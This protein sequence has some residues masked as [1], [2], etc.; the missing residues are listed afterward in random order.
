MSSYIYPA[1]QPREP[2]RD[3]PRRFEG[4]FP[5]CYD[6]QYRDDWEGP[7]LNEMAAFSRECRERERD[8][9]YVQAFIDNFDEFL[10]ELSKW[11]PPR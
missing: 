9:A 1:S 3:D 5:Q 6:L 4:D 10:Q 7:T 8:A 11:Q 2:D